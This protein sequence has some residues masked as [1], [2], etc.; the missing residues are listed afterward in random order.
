[1]HPF[2][3][4]KIFPAPGFFIVLH[5]REWPAEVASGIKKAA[6]AAFKHP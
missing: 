6:I 5:F 4:R 1:M 2:K 3:V